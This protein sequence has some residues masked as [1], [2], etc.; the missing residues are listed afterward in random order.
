M[1]HCLRVTAAVALFNSGEDEHMI[2]FRLRPPRMWCLLLY[3]RSIELRRNDVVNIP[4][5]VAGIELFH[6]SS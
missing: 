4:S 1:A 2:A 6:A 3:S 5:T